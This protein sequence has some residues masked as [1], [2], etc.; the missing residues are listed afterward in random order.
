MTLLPSWRPGAVRDSVVQ[1][2]D[3][4][5]E[6]PPE[7]RLMCFDNDGTLWTEKPNY[8][9]LEFFMDALK[10]R[11]AEDP[12][13]GE[14]PEFAALL[15]GDHAAVGEI[16]LERIALALT[17]LFA[18]QTPEVFAAL[19]RNFFHRV[20]HPTLDRPHRSTVYQPMAE[21][22]AELRQRDVTVAIVTGGGTE[23]VRAVSHDIYGVPPELVVGT[24]IAYD[25]V[26]DADGQ[27]TLLR[28]A[29][30]T[31]AAN[32]GAAKVSNIR[33]QLGRRP[34]AAAGNSGGDREMLEWAAAGQ[35]PTLAL[36][37]NHDDADREFAYASSAETF[38]EYEPITEV[39]ARMGW[40][41]V[42]IATDWETVFAPP[43]SADRFPP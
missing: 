3:A 8:V 28:T 17:G 15:A 9:Q 4:V 16:G 27:P 37:I 30:L 26:R 22:I 34:I 1:F 38:A 5:T 31:G 41:V 7:D 36:L 23:F 33:A 14:S 35:S 40:A 43:G 13:V 12:A 19:V 18:G 21:L 25:F 11:V 29:T 20:D 24:L 6:V 2:L 32:E 42:S 10:S 39:G